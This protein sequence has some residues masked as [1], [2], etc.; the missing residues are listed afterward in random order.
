MASGC[1][2]ATTEYLSTNWSVLAVRKNSDKQEFT[3]SEAGKIGGITTASRYGSDH[4]RMIGHLGQLV[5]AQRYSSEDRRR[6]GRMGGRPRR[7][8]YPEEDG[9]LRQRR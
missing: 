1:Q 7:Q 4:Y 2:E 6:W 8:H 9:N 5:F 3:V